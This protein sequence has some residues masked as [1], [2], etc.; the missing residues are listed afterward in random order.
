MRVRKMVIIASK[1]LGVD[2]LLR[3]FFT[4]SIPSLFGIFVYNA[5]T[6]MVTR[7]ELFG[8]SMSLVLLIKSVVSLM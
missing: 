4:D 6:S 5:D 1:D 2:F 3:V 7:V 8:T